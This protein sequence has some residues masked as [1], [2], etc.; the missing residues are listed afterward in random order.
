MNKKPK[1]QPS[2]SNE[3][4]LFLNQLSL[5]RS[6]APRERRISTLHILK[7]SYE[8]ENLSEENIFMAAYLDPQGRDYWSGWLSEDWVTAHQ[9]I[10]FLASHN[11]RAI[12]GDERATFLQA[13]HK[14]DP[15]LLD[16]WASARVDPLAQKCY[17]AIVYA[18][19][20]AANNEEGWI[21]GR[22]EDLNQSAAS[23][24]LTDI[25][26]QQGQAIKWLFK[27]ADFNHLVPINLK[28]LSSTV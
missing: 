6:L 15:A 1:T 12:Q 14:H 25:E 11:A 9:V 7:Q 13:F 18:F 17:N 2:N 27:H 4:D 8:Y 28:N 22:S 20:V 23:I 24:H 19:S 21:R 10:D 5:C 3:T 16:L 26:F